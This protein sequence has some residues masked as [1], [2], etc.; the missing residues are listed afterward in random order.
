MYSVVAGDASLLATLDADI[1]KPLSLAEVVKDQGFLLQPGN[2]GT[3]KAEQAGVPVEALE[4]GMESK[5]KVLGHMASAM[6]NIGLCTVRSDGALQSPD[7]FRKP[8]VASDAQLTVGGLLVRVRPPPYAFL[9]MS[10]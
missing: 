6:H 7:D 8:L 1:T 5:P 9:P 10:E 4:Q 3:S 2:V